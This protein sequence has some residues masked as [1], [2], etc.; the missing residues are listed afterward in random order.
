MSVLT[1]AKIRKLFRESAINEHGTFELAADEKLTPAAR[2]FLIDH[3]ITII[4]TNPRYRQTSEEEKTIQV[5]RVARLEDSPICANLVKLMR[6]YPYFLKAQGQLYSAFRQD[7]VEQ[8][9]NLLTVIERLVGQCLLE[10]MPLYSPDLPSHVELQ[11]IR[12]SKQLDQS[13]L[14][15]TYQEPT[16]RL[17]CYELYIETV[18][19]RK[20][21]E[22]SVAL[23]RDEFASSLCQILKSVEVLIWLMTSDQG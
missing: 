19:F 7:K 22:Q 4:P 11:A 14:L 10:D 2:E 15:M 21:I 9:G 13:S 5:R 8:L 12:V 20:E 3:H 18:L 16:W 17:A 1:E 23:D 6:L